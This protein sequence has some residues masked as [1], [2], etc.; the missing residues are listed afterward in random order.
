MRVGELCPPKGV[1]DASSSH[2]ELNATQWESKCD[3]K[4]MTARTQ[5][6]TQDRTQTYADKT[7]TVEAPRKKLG[8]ETT[9]SSEGDGTPIETTSEKLRTASKTHDGG[10]KTSEFPLTT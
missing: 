9:N 8:T 4:K 1:E 10:S 7:Q 5:E 2:F 6:T 3:K